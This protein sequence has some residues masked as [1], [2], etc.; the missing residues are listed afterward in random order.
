MVDSAMTGFLRLPL[1]LAFLAFP[2]ALIAHQLDEYLQTTLIAIEPNDIRL[3]I[4]LTPGVAVADKVLALIDRDGNGIISTNEASAYAAL[5]QS[6]LIV[7]LD[8]QPVELKLNAFNF[9]ELSEI[10]TGWGI[11]QMDFSIKHG[12]LTAG[13]HKL[14]L[15]NRHLPAIS[16][17]LFNAEQ[18]ASDSIRIA[19]QERNKTQSIGEIE[20]NYI[21]PPTAS[22]TIKYFASAAG[23]FV[24]LAI[25]IWGPGLATLFS[26]KL[27]V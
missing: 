10:R 3:Q 12:P 11:I 6:D 4:N 8:Q 27:K 24:V 23:L 22:K 19:K 5:L 13:S 18:P 25:A 7:Q 17:Y 14:K 20:F 1:L 15:E 9:P 26:E 16:V 2:S 21:P